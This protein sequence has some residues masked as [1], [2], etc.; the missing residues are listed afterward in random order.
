MIAIE[1]HWVKATSISNQTRVHTD[2]GWKEPSLTSARPEGVSRD[3]D[4]LEGSAS[5]WTNLLLSPAVCRL[6][7]VMRPYHAHVLVFSPREAR[8][9]TTVELV[10]L[11]HRLLTPWGR[12]V[13]MMWAGTSRYRTWKSD[14][15]RIQ[16]RAK[17][18]LK[19]FQGSWVYKGWVDEDCRVL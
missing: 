9:Q 6:L 16:A 11:S 18:R 4:R 12:T 13:W 8:S 1:L 14:L 2:V 10:K 3:V 5:F 17:P 19:A 7:Q 15:G